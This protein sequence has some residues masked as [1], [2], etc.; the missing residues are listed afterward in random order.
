MVSKQEIFKKAVLPIILTLLL[1]LISIKSI[2]LEIKTAENTASQFARSEGMLYESVLLLTKALSGAEGAETDQMRLRAVL[3]GEIAVPSLSLPGNVTSS[4]LDYYAQV[5][6]A[7]SPID[8]AL[9]AYASAL[10]DHMDTARDEN[11][12]LADSFPLLGSETGKDEEGLS[13]LPLSDKIAAPLAKAALGGNVST[14]IP[15]RQENGSLVYL[16][17]GAYVTVSPPGRV[18]SFLRQMPDIEKSLLTEEQITARATRFLSSVGYSLCTT[19]DTITEENG[20]WRLTA[21]QGEMRI[22]LTLSGLSGAVYAL[23]L[24]TSL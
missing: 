11:R 12:S 7:S 9:V 10:L 4:L 5:K 18:T 1:L 8:P 16:L 23:R 3:L 20:Y 21:T 17:S 24:E 14:P 15:I 22:T 6:T 2:L 13:P 19:F